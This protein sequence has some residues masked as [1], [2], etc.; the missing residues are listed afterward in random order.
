MEDWDP[1][2]DTLDYIFHTPGIT[3][4]KVKRKFLLF[5]ARLAFDT[6]LED[7][8]PSL[9]CFVFACSADSPQLPDR[10]ADSVAICDNSRIPIGMQV[11]RH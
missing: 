10:V 9:H 11:Y 1:F 6:T 8:D 3:A 7:A 2:I 5:T 4:T